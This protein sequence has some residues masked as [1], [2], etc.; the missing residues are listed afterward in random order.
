MRRWETISEIVID[1]CILKAN[2]K[3]QNYVPIKTTHLFEL[4]HLD[5]LTIESGK[6]NKRCEY[7]NYTYHFT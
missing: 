4:I 3:G 7:L 6:T 5:F 2:H 1:G